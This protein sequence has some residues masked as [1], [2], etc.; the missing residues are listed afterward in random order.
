MPPLVS[1]QPATDF[2]EKLHEK[3]YHPV[4]DADRKHCELVYYRPVLFRSY[5]GDIAERGWVGNRVPAAQT[6]KHTTHKNACATE[7][8]SASKPQV[9]LHLRVNSETPKTRINSSTL[10]KK[11]RQDLLQFKEVKS[12]SHSPSHA[13]ERS[14][15][16]EILHPR[17]A[18]Q[19]SRRWIVKRMT[20]QLA[21]PR[22]LVEYKVITF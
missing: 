15:M 8:A 5:R 20:K 9:R 10:V 14:E 11:A 18:E 22:V 13:I 21:S 2:S 17:Q 12:K 4:W 7:T 1:D 3:E 6:D 16:N 19:D